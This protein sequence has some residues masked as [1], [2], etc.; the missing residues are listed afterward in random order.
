MEMII[1]VFFSFME[2]TSHP[3]VR[4]DDDDDE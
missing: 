1:R 4:D 2:I 3:E